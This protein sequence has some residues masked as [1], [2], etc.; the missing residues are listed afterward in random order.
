M[1]SLAAILFYVLVYTLV[2]KRRTPQNI[3]WGGA[4][5]CMPVLIGWAAVTG[6]L[7]WAPLILFG[8]V[9]LWTPPH[10]WPLSMRYRDDYASVQR[11]DAR[12]GPRPHGRRPAGRA[13]RLGDRRV[14][15][16]A[17]P[18]RR[19]GSLYAVVALAAG[20][21]FIFEAHRLYAAA[22]RDGEVKPMRVFHARIT[23]L[24]LVFLAVGIDPLLPF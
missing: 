5:G 21:W 7:D 23:Y 22:I 6:S 4:A 16:A 24:T 15:A 17:H 20:G 2:L 8:I 19:M 12:R 10:Y 14:L 1:L 3:V 9:F 13:V 11:A 18:G